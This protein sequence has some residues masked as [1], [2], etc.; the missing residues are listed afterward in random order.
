MK[1]CSISH[2]IPMNVRKKMCEEVKVLVGWFMTM[3]G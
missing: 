1:V 2:N 3:V